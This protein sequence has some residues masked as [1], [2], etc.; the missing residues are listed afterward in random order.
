MI[1]KGIFIAIALS[2][3]IVAF[4]EL[5]LAVFDKWRWSDVSSMGC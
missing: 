2:V 5:I 1:P 3:C 4:I